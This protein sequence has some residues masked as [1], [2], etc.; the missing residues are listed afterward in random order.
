MRTRAKTRAT[1]TVVACTILALIGLG[2][3]PVL[4]A[5]AQASGDAS[6]ATASQALWNRQAR[7]PVAPRGLEIS[8]P[9][10]QP[11]RFVPLTLDK[12]GMAST[13][14]AA[15]LESTAAARRAP[16]VLSLPTPDGDFARFSVEESPVV[17]P[18]LAAR[19]P[20]ITTYGGQ[21]I[22]DPRAT[23]RLDLGLTGFHAQVLSPHGSWYIDPY[24]HLDDS[25]Y[26]SY[27]GRDLQAPRDPFFEP[28][29]GGLRSPVAAPVAGAQSRSTGTQLRTYR[30][31]LAADGEYS[32]L[33][34]GTK[35]LVLN[36]LVTAVNRVSGIYQT[37]L[38]I[39]LELVANDDKLIY[40]N[41]STDPYS[42]TNASALLTQNQ[43][44]IDNV[45]GG[46]NYDIGHV[47]TT[48]GGGYASLA[49]V[50]KPG[51][52]AQGETGNPSPTGD[53][54]W[55]DYVAH[56]MGHQFGANHTFNGIGLNC[57]GTNANSLTAMEPGSGSSIMAYAGICGSDD[58]QPHSDPFF[59]AVSFDEIVAY[60][61]TVGSPGNL[62]AASTSNGAPTVAVTGGPYTIPIR[63]PFALSATGSDPNGDALT[64]QWEQYDGGATRS[65]T[66]TSKPSGALFRSFAP[67]TSSTRTFPKLSSILANN[68]D[69]KTGTCAVLPAGLNCWSEFLP[70]VG[71][72][73]TF[74]VTARD[75]RSDGGGV[76][77]ADTTVT[78]APTGPFQ[79]TSP[80]TAVT[81]SG[82]SAPTVAWNVASTNVAPVNT[83]NVDILLSTDGGNTFPTV[84]ESNAPNDGTQPVTLPNVETTQ[85]RVKIAAVGNVYFDISDANFT[86]TSSAGPPPYQPDGMIR[87]S[88]SSIYLG[89]NIYNIT[90]A[91]QSAAKTVAVGYTATYYVKLQNDGTRSDAIKVKGCAGANGFTVTYKVGTLNITTQVAAGTYQTTSLGV[92]AYKTLTAKVKASTLA[93]GQT[94][95]CLITATSAGD[96][97]R[98]DVVSAATTGK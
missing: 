73:M 10:V 44:N 57:A 18:E 28:A 22:D 43:T 96:A 3:V 71:R 80:N 7:V 6:R 37:E 90:G 91:G 64:Y 81:L 48:G 2:L 31:A 14:A 24:Y 66:S 38:A 93:R 20:Q 74:R 98:T 19:Y 15:P 62:G 4:A 33:W 87:P 40:L 21:G 78:V 79:V 27:Y 29:I 95:T 92:G 94:L 17:A 82:G 72:S 86:I 42:N 50:G 83:A 69:A 11:N 1:R 45:I 89:N 25:V 85:A 59:H 23:I 16:L 56:E 35:A 26:V 34:G 61:T 46:A 12:T 55:V 51:L 68:T 36:A 75:N 39:K 58:L 8:R 5:S 52:K 30:L 76:S 77:S 9:D 32:A 60:T 49:V 88:T 65:L 47:F 84:L 67:T 70:T 97:T 53:A 54:F 63:T 13:L 41:P